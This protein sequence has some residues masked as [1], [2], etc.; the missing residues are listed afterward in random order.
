MT[1]PLL[2]EIEQ[3]LAREDVKLSETAFGKQ[4]VN[5]GKFIPNLRSGRRVWPE[6]ADR[7]RSFM[8]NFAGAAAGEQNDDAAPGEPTPA[9]EES[10]QPHPTRAA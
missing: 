5:D 10:A 2:Q 3:F 4:A 1:T 9:P 8:A 6:T 7:I